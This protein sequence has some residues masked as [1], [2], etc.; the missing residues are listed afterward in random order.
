MLKSQLAKLELSTQHVIFTPGDASDF[1]R[2]G[3]ITT[4]DLEVTVVN[5]SQQFASFQLSLY[6]QG[7]EQNPDT[8]W[9]QVEPNVCAKKPPGDRTT[10]FISLL[11]AP[12]PAYDTTVTATVEVVSPE[13]SDLSLSKQ[14]Y[15]KI[16]RPNKTLRVY[17]PVKDLSVY[18]GSR[19][20]IPVLLYNLNPQPREVTLRLTGAELDWFPEGAVQTL[21]IEASGSREVEYWCAPPPVPETL[22]EVR[23]ITAEVNDRDGNT[24]SARSY[25]E[26]LPFGH[27][28]FCMT[29]SQQTIPGRSAVP[30]R[31][32]LLNPSLF[33]SKRK[34]TAVFPYA[35]TNHSNIHQRVAVKIR[36]E[37][38]RQED[39]IDARVIV[40][41]PGETGEGSLSIEARRPWLG[42]TR[43]RFLEVAPQLTQEASQEDTEDITVK[44]ASQ[45]ATL[46]VSPLIPMWLQLLALL[47]GLLGVWLVWLLSPRLVHRSPIN[48]VALLANGDSVIS[49]S[50]DQTVHRWQVNRAAWLPNVRRVRPVSK[51]T[52]PDTN[53]N[54]AVRVVEH[55]PDNVK[56]VAIGLDNGEVQLWEIDPPTR[57]KSF[58][59]KNNNRVFDVAFTRSS[60]HLFTGYGSGNVLRWSL[61]GSSNTPAQKLYLGYSEDLSS[62]ISSIDVIEAPGQ[63]SLVAIAG[64][65]NRLT[66]WD[67]QSSRA[68]DFLY[69]WSSSQ[70]GIPPV[71]SRHSYLTSIDVAA[72][73]PLMATADSL[74]FITLWDTTQMRRCLQEQSE[75]SSSNASGNQ[76]Y[77]VSRCPQAQLEQWQAGRQGSA[78]RDVALTDNG[79]YL[80]STGDDGRI[81]LWLLGQTG[82]LHRQSPVALASFPNASLNSVD[83]H[84]TSNN[85]VLAAADIPGPRVQVYRK[86]LS[87]HGCQ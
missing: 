12:L 83:L 21:L 10:F 47:A 73:T 62:A 19:V 2:D 35:V 63:N 86:Q 17:L 84:L 20:R 45:V 14:L 79:C 57:I 3:D 60:Q 7:Q 34:G 27:T 78:V 22:R 50:R 36:P 28:E 81:N 41:T 30:L 75:A 29:D 85:T 38:L 1:S 59:D 52:A 5:T 8:Q 48:S 46:K 70:T 13:L 33:Q 77:I 65:F 53:F 71:I 55:L 54:H 4:S 61:S 24:V 87:G 42:W 43:K 56:E 18:P 80:T 68:Y 82:Q 51:I 69:D 15:I 16:L 44:P 64:Q 37:E 39:R 76:F 67:W 32:R 9:Y 49:G 58:L 11:K 25:L 31:Q 74:G 72:D 6:I 26:I 23:T 66:L 40:L